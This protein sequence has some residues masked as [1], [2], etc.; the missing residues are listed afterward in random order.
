MSLHCQVYGDLIPVSFVLGF[1]VSVVIK[2]WWDQYLC[3]PWPDNLALFVSSLVHGQVT[4]QQ[5]SQEEDHGSPCKVFL[6]CSLPQ[7][8]RGR[9]M[10]R[11]I[12]RYVNLS[13][14]LTLR[15]ISPRVKKRFP[16]LD[17]V[18][19]AGWMLPGEKKIFEDLEHKTPH[20]K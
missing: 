15:M 2:R 7:D 11:T 16:T 17:H 1:Y 8:E 14:L 13:L 4:F 3:L 18:V 20:T 6:S 12:M 9:I 5:I 10:R 19:E